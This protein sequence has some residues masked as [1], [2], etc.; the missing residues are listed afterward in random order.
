MSTS[1]PKSYTLRS[2]KEYDVSRGSVR[3]FNELALDDL[4]WYSRLGA[5]VLKYSFRSV[6]V[7]CLLITSIMISLS[8]VGSKSSTPSHKPYIL[9]FIVIHIFCG[10]GN[11]A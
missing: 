11:M 8:I 3:K 9:W 5:L 6:F 10:L 4:S 2:D 1:S 7:L